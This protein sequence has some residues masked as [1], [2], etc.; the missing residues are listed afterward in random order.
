MQACHI[1]VC[2]GTQAEGAEAKKITYSHKGP[3]ESKI[4]AKRW[5]QF[6]KTQVFIFIM[7][8]NV[9][10]A[11][12]SHVAKLNIKGQEVFAHSGRGRVVNS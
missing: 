1:C 2:W 10:L 4:Q 11:K 9:P 6:F 8:S 5:K 3:P 12:V 7:F